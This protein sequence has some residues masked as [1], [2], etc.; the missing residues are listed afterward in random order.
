M[1]RHTRILAAAIGCALASSAALAAK[2]VDLTERLQT[3]L[4]DKPEELKG[5]YTALFTEGERN[6]VLN[7]NR[8]GLAAMQTGRYDLAER[9]FDAALIRIEQIYSND[10]QARKAKSKFAAESVKDFKG[11]P[12]ERAMAYYYRGLLFLRTGDFENARASFIAGEYQDTVAEK[13]EYS[14]DFDSLVFL[15]GWASRCANDPAKADE[16]FGRVASGRLPH[17]PPTRRCC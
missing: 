8:V 4:E 1:I 10:P 6:A 11:E 12:Y 7:F 13:E 16:Y 9:A 15:A 17:P 5:L 3:Y 14:S 2:P